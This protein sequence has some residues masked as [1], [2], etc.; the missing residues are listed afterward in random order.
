MTA[1]EAL[2]VMLTFGLLIFSLLAFVMSVLFF[3]IKKQR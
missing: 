1:Y 2:M 3:L